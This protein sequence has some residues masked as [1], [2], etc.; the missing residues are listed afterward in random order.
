MNDTFPALL[1]GRA[2]PAE[3]IQTIWEAE[4]SWKQ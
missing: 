3:I 2:S 1:E 4:R